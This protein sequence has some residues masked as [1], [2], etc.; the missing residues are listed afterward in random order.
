MVTCSECQI[1]LPDGT[2]R[3][4]MCGRLVAWPKTVVLIVAVAL[5]ALLGLALWGSGKLKSKMAWGETRPADAYKAAMAFVGKDPATHGAVSFSKLEET[6]V[7]R[8]DVGRWR[9][10]GFVDTQPKPGVKIH[11]LYYCVLRNTGSDHWAIEDLQ[12]ERVE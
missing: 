12:F 4:P 3:C 7:E 9:V 2:S 1:G 6:L 11:T 8:W 10:A 5:T